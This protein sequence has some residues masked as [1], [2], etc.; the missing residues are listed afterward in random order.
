MEGGDLV[1]KYPRIQYLYSMRIFLIFCGILIFLCKPSYT[2]EINNEKFEWYLKNTFGY[3]NSVILNS[4]ILE[5]Q[6]ILKLPFFTGDIGVSIHSFSQDISTNFRFTPYKNQYIQVGFKPFFHAGIFGDIGKEIDVGSLAFIEISNQEKQNAFTFLLKVGSF[7]KFTFIN[8][9]PKHL[10]D[11]ELLFSIAFAQR[12]LE[13]HEIS[14]FIS[15][16]EDYYYPLF[17]NPSFHLRYTHNIQGKYSI[18]GEAFVRY[19][20]MLTLTGTIDGFQVKLFYTLKLP[21]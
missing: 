2:E 18:G 5:I 12:F 19:T 11:I 1:A 16:Y 3:E 15:S 9:I 14:F 17:L 10:R 8:L 21:L 4:P 13:N 7:Y 20:D 6:A